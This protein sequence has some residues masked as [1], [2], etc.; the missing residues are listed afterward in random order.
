MCVWLSAWGVCSRDVKNLTFVYYVTSGPGP[1]SQALKLW[2]IGF[3]AVCSTV[4]WYDTAL[5]N[6]LFFVYCT[7]HTTMSGRLAVSPSHPCSVSKHISNNFT[8]CS[9]LPNETSLIVSDEVTRSSLEKGIKYMWGM[10]NSR[11]STILELEND[12]Q[13]IRAYITHNY[14]DLLNYAITI[15][16]KHVIKYLRN[17]ITTSC[18]IM[19]IKSRPAPRGR[20]LPPGE[21]NGMIA[22]PL[23]VHTESF[24]TIVAT[25]FM[26]LT[27]KHCCKQV[28]NEQS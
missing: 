27:N 8:I 13:C 19:H 26:L 25:V 22:E 23:P 5:E 3:I 24:M 10:K 11:F 18:R 17:W 9:S 16:L 21:F 2:K 14:Y 12:V 6:A 15:D 1:L 20:V 4:H 7:T 28:T